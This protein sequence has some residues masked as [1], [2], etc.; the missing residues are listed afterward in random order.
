MVKNSKKKESNNYEKEVATRVVGNK[1]KG[2]VT[3]GIALL[4]VDINLVL[5]GHLL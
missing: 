2:N 3:V 1:G 4:R 5:N